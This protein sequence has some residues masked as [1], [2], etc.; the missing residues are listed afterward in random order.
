MVVVVATFTRHAL[1]PEQIA[2]IGVE[3]YAKALHF[4][5]LASRTLSSLEEARAVWQDMSTQLR[6]RDVHLYGV[7]PAALRAVLLE[8]ECREEALHTRYHLRLFEALNVQRAVEGRKPSFEHRGW[9]VTGVY[10]PRS[11]QLGGGQ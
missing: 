11:L 1:T 5:A 7:I 9:L 10:S 3:R 8:D 6:G 2:E 4:P